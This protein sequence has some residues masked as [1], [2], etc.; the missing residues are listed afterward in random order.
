VERQQV[1]IER[2]QDNA[3]SPQAKLGKNLSEDPTASGVSIQGNTASTS[4]NKQKKRNR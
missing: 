1:D 2:Q 4:A 3:Q